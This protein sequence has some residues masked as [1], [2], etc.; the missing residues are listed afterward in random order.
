[1]TLVTAKASM[2]ADSTIQKQYLTQLQTIGRS[3]SRP[4]RQQYVQNYSLPE[5][6]FLAK[7]DSARALLDGVL[8]QYRSQLDA[9]FVQQQEA[10]IHY[11][12]DRLLADYPTN[13]AIYTGHTYPS[14]P[15]I[16]KRL[17]KNLPDFNRIDLLANSDFTDYVRAFFS[18]QI[19][20]ELNKPS[21]NNTDNQELQ[22]VWK[23]IPNYVT[24]PTCREF[25]Y[26]NYLVNHIENK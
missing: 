18:F 25:W 6:K 4:F 10:E 16:T 13:Y 26:Y 23:L 14:H 2:R 8:N 15:L 21:Y 24:N 9:A 3:F 19:D 20:H 22:A 17:E 11:Y 5:S 1:M 12:F 7:I